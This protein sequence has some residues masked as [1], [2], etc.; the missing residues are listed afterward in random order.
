M[1]TLYIP[2][3]SSET[4]AVI[5]QIAAHL[6]KGEYNDARKVTSAILPLLAHNDHLKRNLV[7]I[8]HAA[9]TLWEGDQA[10]KRQRT[11]YFKVNVP[12]LP[13]ALQKPYVKLRACAPEG[14]AS[15]DCFYR[16]QALALRS[17]VQSP[18][19]HF[20]K[21]DRALPN[22]CEFL[23]VEDLCAF[24]ACNREINYQIKEEM[25]AIWEKHAL[26]LSLPDDYW[27]N[28]DYSKKRCVENFRDIYRANETLRGYAE[29][30]HGERFVKC[31]LSLSGKKY[32]ELRSNIRDPQ[33]RFQKHT[34][35]ITN[36]VVEG[37]DNR[38]RSIRDLLSGMSGIEARDLA[39]LLWTCGYTKS[40]SSLLCLILDFAVNNFAV[41][42][43]NDSLNGW[44]S[45]IVWASSRSSWK[46]DPDL[47]N[48]FWTSNVIEW[49]LRAYAALPPGKGERLEAHIHDCLCS[50]LKIDAYVLNQYCYYNREYLSLKL[51]PPLIEAI[52][53]QKR[54]PEFLEG[55]VARCFD[56]DPKYR[57]LT[58]Y[59]PEEIFHAIH[60][61]KPKTNALGHVSLNQPY[62]F[63]FGMKTQCR[64]LIELLVELGVK[65]HGAIRRSARDLQ[66]I[67]TSL[68]IALEDKAPLAVIEQLAKMGVPAT[69]ETP[70][71][72]EAY[73][74][75]PETQ[76]KL[77]SA[78]NAPA[79]N[80]SF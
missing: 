80:P 57:L 6:D 27:P 61:F 26:S 52:Q 11:I 71:L 59:T 33:E 49:M 67:S 39:N 76:G 14:A 36:A 75:D 20:A 47:G 72:V 2:N 65:T 35:E 56:P 9:P 73:T 64:E 32:A 79:F 55:F 50:G 19:G 42:Q 37:L 13:P 15:W 69:D 53:D 23:K 44:I 51:L 62:W 58:Y 30:H 60:Q 10:P 45:T 34:R 1:T 63:Y 38:E 66:T 31:L 46:E 8:I 41:R 77:L 28:G 24:S 25:A 43:D 18:V 74:Q 68:D 3:V 22:I 48:N 70:G 7:S 78:L 5:L 54:V 21:R 16:A 40:V 29:R 17:L 12:D 4:R